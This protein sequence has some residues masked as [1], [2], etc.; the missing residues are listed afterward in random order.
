MPS[1]PS[2]ALAAAI[3]LSV[4][5]GAT[6]A[7]TETVNVSKDSIAGAGRNIMRT[8]DG[9]LV[10]AYSVSEKARLQLVFSRST[11]NGKS[12]SD[13]I[14]P[15]ADGDV[16]QAA[17]DSNFQG[18]YIAFTQE[19]GGTTA[20]RIA[21]ASAPFGSDPSLVVSERVTPAGVEPNDTFIQASR[22]GWG[23]LAADDRET[24]VYGWQDGKSKSLYIGVSS[25]GRTFPM[26][27]KVV[28]DP[29]AVSGPS[30]AIRGNFVIAT[31]QTKNP[32]MVP[33]DV[34]APGG[35]YPVWVESFDAG[36]T[37]S[38]P[39][40]LFGIRTDDF[41]AVNVEVRP[42]A[43]KAV[44]LAGGTSQSNSPSL[45]WATSRD[46][47]SNEEAEDK[48]V[49]RA[50]GAVRAPRTDGGTTF[51]QSSLM[52]VDSEGR[53][54]EVSVVS[55]RPIEPGA[56]WTHVI[57]HNKLTQVAGRQSRTASLADAAASQFQYSALIDTSVRA[58]LFQE[59][60]PGSDKSRLVIAVSTDTGKSFGIN[61]SFSAAELAGLGIPHLGKS[62]IVS[63]SQCLFED[64][65]GEV[66][67]DLLVTEGGA[68]KYA[69][70]PLGVNA[71]RLR[72]E[73]TVARRGP[74]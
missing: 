63:A 4:V 17:I 9:G 52:R 61:V 71:S 22:K 54:G 34:S 3:S 41:P 7:G 53:R 24:V 66:Y 8:A 47:D 62:T 6:H 5:V 35:A 57:A 33:A 30:V 55:F 18:S 19:S 28:D 15:T 49:P 56:K 73:Q 25:D 16:R 1:S 65:N 51:V 11:D 39:K 44:R 48:T 74:D 29:F 58:T 70:L 72:V 64:R 10:S 36:K 40:P 67:I 69:R 46:D 42:G 27:R 43:F 45:N 12:W 13:V 68:L 59:H 60:D 50:A 2:S 31:F 20:G 14:V 23:N 38:T 21:F 26:A 37:W 32:A